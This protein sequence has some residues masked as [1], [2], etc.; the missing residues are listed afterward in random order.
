MVTLKIQKE[1]REAYTKAL[2]NNL[3]DD[4]LRKIASKTP[5]Y[6]LYWARD[7][8][9]GPHQVTMEGVMKDPAWAYAYHCD[10]L[11]R[12]TWELYNLLK[13]TR[14]ESKFFEC[15]ILNSQYKDEIMKC[16][17]RIYEKHFNSKDF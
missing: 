6:A 10:I 1:A 15:F 9:H 13:D 2:L 17:L 11:K 3:K 5:V 14:Y 4:E 16:M 8:D 12:P 7:I